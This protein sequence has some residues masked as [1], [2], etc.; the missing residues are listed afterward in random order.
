MLDV[1]TPS[2][3]SYEMAALMPRC[4]VCVKTWGTH[5]V[6]LEYPDE[7]GGRIV[8]FIERGRRGG[9]K[10]KKEKKKKK[11]RVRSRGRSRGER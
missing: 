10:E 6:M 4:E 3:H 2:Y 5:F 9:R 7:V 1:L 11:G 8:E